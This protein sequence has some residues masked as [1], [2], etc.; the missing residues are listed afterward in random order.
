MHLAWTYVIY[1]L[2]D[3]LLTISK[4]PKMGYW[5]EILGRKKNKNVMCGVH[6]CMRL[7][8]RLCPVNGMSVWCIHW[9]FATIQSHMTYDRY[10][11]IS[12]TQ[13]W[14]ID[15]LL[16]LTDYSPHVSVSLNFMA[17]LRCFSMFRVRSIM[18]LRHMVL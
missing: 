17:A 7:R 3:V 1:L 9:F 13:M 5:G 8:E 18:A 16:F 15:L 14:L 10:M 2:I 6:V 12:W 4:N 11:L